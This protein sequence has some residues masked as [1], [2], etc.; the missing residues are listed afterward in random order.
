MSY[1]GH[2]LKVGV[3]P[4][5]SDAVGAFYSHLTLADFALTDS[6]LKNC[7]LHL[8]KNVTYS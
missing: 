8:V 1:P 3:L 7:L 2:S 4:L 5:S 6:C